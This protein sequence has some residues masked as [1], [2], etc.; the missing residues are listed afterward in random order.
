MN[1]VNVQE[2]DTDAMKRLCVE[3]LT[4]A[5]LIDCLDAQVIDSKMMKAEAQL[6]HDVFTGQ[7]GSCEALRAYLLEIA[8]RSFDGHSNNDLYEHLNADSY[9]LY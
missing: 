3:Q 1:I 2:L 6:M 8:E 5:D 7:A 4:P 9:D